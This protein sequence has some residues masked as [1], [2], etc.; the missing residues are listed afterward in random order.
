[1]GCQYVDELTKELKMYKEQCVVDARWMKHLE[2]EN[3]RLKHKL[4]IIKKQVED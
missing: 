4:S 1:M 3:K 2:Q